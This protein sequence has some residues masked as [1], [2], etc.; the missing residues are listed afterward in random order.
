MNTYNEDVVSNFNWTLNKIVLNE[1]QGATGAT[2]ATGPQG[3]TGPQGIQGLQGNTGA[4]GPYPT[5]IYSELFANSTITTTLANNSG[6]FPYVTVSNAN[7]LSG[8][9]SPGVSYN[10]TDTITINSQSNTVIYEFIMTIGCRKGESTSNGVDIG[11]SI[12]GVDPIVGKYTRI[13]SANFSTTDRELSVSGLFS[14]SP[15]VSHTIQIRVRQSA[16]GAAG[17]N[18]I[19]FSSLNFSIRSINMT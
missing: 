15:S 5:M 8:L 6:P 7:L 1:L 9:L 2:G 16:G 12:D 4:T 10:G 3:N 17:T 13:P 11:I 19:V 14:L 18:S